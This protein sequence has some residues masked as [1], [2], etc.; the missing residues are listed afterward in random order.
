MLIEESSPVGRTVRITS[1]YSVGRPTLMHRAS[2]CTDT[3]YSWE[4]LMMAK[5]ILNR[6]SR[7][8]LNRFN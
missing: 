8:I 3:I 6:G 2:R 1:G 5:L 7:E 4:G